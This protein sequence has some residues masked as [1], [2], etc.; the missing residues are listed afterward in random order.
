M[1][2]HLLVNLLE[3]NRTSTLA[4]D[5]FAPRRKSLSLVAQPSAAEKGVLAQKTSRQKHTPTIAIDTR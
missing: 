3:Q 1:S 5:P 2:G 4:S